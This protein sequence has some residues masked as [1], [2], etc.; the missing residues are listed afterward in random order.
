MKD[1][2]DTQDAV[3]SGG[4]YNGRSIFEVMAG[5]TKADLL[6]FLDFVIANP[7]NYAGGTWKLTETFATWVSKNPL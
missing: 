3:V 2:N 5:C 6:R 4:I 1:N 7:R